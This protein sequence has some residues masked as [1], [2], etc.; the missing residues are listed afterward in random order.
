MYLSKRGSVWYIW[1]VDEVTG[2]KRKISTHT[3]NKSAALIELAQFVSTASAK[4]LIPKT[5]NKTV[6][7]FLPELLES[8]APMFSH[9][10]LEIYERAM[11]KFVGIAGDLDLRAITPRHADSFKAERLKQSSPTTTNIDL[12]TLKA[13]FNTAIRWEYMDRNPFKGIKFVPIPERAPSFF[14]K[15]HFVAFAAT[16]TED[17]FRNIVEFAVL[18]GLRR[19]ELVNLRWENVDMQRGVIQIESTATFK[20]KSG[21][22]R[23]VPLNDSAKKVLERV[24]HHNKEPWVFTFQ[25]RQISARLVTHKLKDCLRRAKLDKPGLHFHSLRHTFASWL[26]QDGISIYAVKE[27]LGHSDVK[28]TQIYSHL[29]GSAL[30]KEVNHIVLPIGK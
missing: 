18:T 25:E 27:L 10:T 3:S 22:R 26:V 24:S 30:H 21:K 15:E 1:T 19:G 14:T 8:N 17:W 5:P 4:K 7:E 28:I 2:K 29:Q 6:S 16:I 9:G 12:R 23:L 11:K 20:T 13:A